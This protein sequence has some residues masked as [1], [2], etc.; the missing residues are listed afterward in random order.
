MAELPPTADAGTGATVPP[1]KGVKPA[2]AFVDP[3]PMPEPTEPEADVPEA[4][5]AEPEL[6]PNEAEAGVEITADNDEGEGPEPVPARAPPLAG[7]PAVEVE[8]PELVAG[9]TGPDG[10]A[11]PS[12]TPA[13]TRALAPTGPGANGKGPDSV[14]PVP[15]ETPVTA[16][17][18]APGLSK[19]PTPGEA[20]PISEGSAATSRP[21]ATATAS[22]GAGATTNPR[23]MAAEGSDGRKTGPSTL[24]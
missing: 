6:D 5:K 12:P 4:G 13:G 24:R 3:V 21:A 17:T 14:G 22:D 7:V 18:E 16:K 11:E 1:A 20:R 23:V 19:E 10:L 15:S 9:V 8:P 2:A